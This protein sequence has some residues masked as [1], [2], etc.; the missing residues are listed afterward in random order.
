MTLSDAL[1]LLSIAAASP[2]AQ[3][4]SITGQA[5]VVDGDTLEIGGV[6]FRLWGMDAP[7]SDQRCTDAGNLPYACGSLAADALEEEIAGA[8]VTCEPSNKDRYGRWVAICTARNH[9]LGE[10]MVARGYA[11]DYRLYSGGFYAD[12]EKEARQ[13]KRG[14]WIGRFERPWEWRRG[15]R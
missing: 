8:P 10:A 15:K 2:A 7:E 12:T 11:L 3:P 9:D 5:R 1:L 4:Q 6:K 13:A 14:M